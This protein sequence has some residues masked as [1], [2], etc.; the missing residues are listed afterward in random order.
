MIFFLWF[1]TSAAVQ[2]RAVLGRHRV[3]WHTVHVPVKGSYIKP[4][5]KQA[6]LLT[7]PLAA[8]EEECRIRL[9]LG[10]GKYVINCR[11]VPLAKKTKTAEGLW[12]CQLFITASGSLQAC[13]A[14]FP[15]PWWI[16]LLRVGG[17]LWDSTVSHL[18]PLSVT[19]KPLGDF[20]LVIFSIGMLYS[21]NSL[22][23]FILTH[24][25]NKQPPLQYIWHN[26]EMVLLLWML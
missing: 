5:N 20:Q 25:L 14:F 1:Y 15:D 4:L 12:S 11:N 9:I 19:E 18:P 16:L 10:F 26:I 7:Q 13:S 2:V 24:W 22:H 8:Q 23:C 17:Y 3:S 6:W 21:W